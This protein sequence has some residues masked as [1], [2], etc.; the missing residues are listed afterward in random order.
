[1]QVILPPFSSF[2]L[3]FSGSALLAFGPFVSLFALIIYQKAQLVIIV[4]TAAFFF[5]L[6]SLAAS[7]TWVCA[8]MIL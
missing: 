7:L 3:F 4:T 1:M 8:L 6:G 2:S 5:L